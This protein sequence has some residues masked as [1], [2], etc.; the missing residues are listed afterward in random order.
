MRGG[1]ATTDLGCGAAAALGVRFCDRE[2]EPF[3]PVGATLKNV[4]TVDTSRARELLDGVELTVMCDI[5]NPLTGEHGA[6]C[7]F[8]PQKGAD[9]KTVHE[10]DAGLAH[11]AGIIRSDLGIDVEHTPGAG[12]AGG[13]AGGLMAFCEASIRPGIDVLL[14][15]AGFPA[16]IND[17]DLVITGEGQI[18]GQSLAGKVPVGVARWVQR[19]RGGELPVVVLAGAI[20]P[21][22]EEV[23][24][25]GIR[26]VF[27]I[28]R[29]PET[30]ADAIAHTAFNLEAA[31]RDVVRLWSA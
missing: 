23:Y 12:A 14:D 27:P 19:H 9:D 6:A 28:G 11:V 20:G 13:L 25:E 30:L 10:L 3:V 22:V 1:S 4:A 16:V 24:R 5:D 31:A 26:A 2:G 7:V 29:G 18:D 15:A 21:D 17:A 8:G